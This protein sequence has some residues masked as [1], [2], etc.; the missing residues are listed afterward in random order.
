MLVTTSLFKNVIYK[1]YMYKQD[2]VLNNLQWLISHKTQPTKDTV[3]CFKQILEEALYKMAVVQPLTSHLT[4]HW[5]KM[6]KTCSTL[7]REV[8]TNSLVMFSLD[9]CTNTPMLADQQRLT[10]IRSEQRIEDLLKAMVD[11]NRWQE[12]VKGIHLHAFISQR[13]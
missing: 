13:C 1:I 11:R 7:L 4:N 10:F 8:R 9:S 2:L 5:I 12:R 3:F 6:S